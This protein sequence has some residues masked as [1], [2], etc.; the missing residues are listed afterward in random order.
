MILISVIT[1]LF[2]LFDLAVRYG[3]A[4]LELRDNRG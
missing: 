1:Y 2:K 4:M 3:T